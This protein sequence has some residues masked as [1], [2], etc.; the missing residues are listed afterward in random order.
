MHPKVKGSI[1][2]QM[3]VCIEQHIIKAV[4]DEDLAFTISKKKMLPQID[5]TSKKET[6]YSLVPKLHMVCLSHAK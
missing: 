3:F 2:N 4:D 1:L 6:W 5:D